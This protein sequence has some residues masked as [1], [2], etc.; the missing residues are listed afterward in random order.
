MIVQVT[1]PASPPPWRWGL[2]FFAVAWDT[3]LQDHIPHQVLARVSSW[4]LLTS[5]LA[6]P[7]GNALAGPLSEAYGS[8]RVLVVCAAVLFAAG[9]APLALRSTRRL[10]R[11]AEPVAPPVPVG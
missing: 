6:M 2:T 3:A 8:N 1:G 5:F 4:D 9:L 11:R 10:T 7:V